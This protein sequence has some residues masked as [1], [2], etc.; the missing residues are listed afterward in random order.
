MNR[1]ILLVFAS[2]IITAVLPLS[3]QDADAKFTCDSTNVSSF[4]DKIIEVATAAKKEGDPQKALDLLVPFS[5]GL[6]YRLAACAKLNFSG[7]GEEQP[8][9][10]PLEIPDGVYRVTVKTDGYFSLQ[11]DTISGNCGDEKYL[12][13]ITKGDAKNGAQIVLKP[14][15]Q[16][17][18]LLTVSNA[19][20]PWQLQFEN[21]SG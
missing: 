17:K 19:S 21:L 10:G 15:D 14:S 8:V 13:L 1:F 6:D 9:L 11:M 16:C 18:A 20:D 4:L 5:N 2:L 7:T 12:F 3:A